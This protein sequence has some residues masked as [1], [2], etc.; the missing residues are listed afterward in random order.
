MKG[1]ARRTVKTGGEHAPFN[2]VE[3]RVFGER[4][5]TRWVVHEVGG[6]VGAVIGVDPEYTVGGRVGDVEDARVVVKFHVAGNAKHVAELNVGIAVDDGVGV[7]VV[8]RIVV[9]GKV[10]ANQFAVVAVIVPV[11]VV[12]IVS[13]AHAIG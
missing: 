1:D 2:A 8:A 3:P 9:F 12:L 7:V 5:E 6:G 11:H 4:L 10:V 13:N